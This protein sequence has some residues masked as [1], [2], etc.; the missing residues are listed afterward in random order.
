MKI[1]ILYERQKI[2]FRRPCVF[3]HLTYYNFTFIYG[4]RKK[5]VPNS[6]GTVVYTIDMLGKFYSARFSFQARRAADLII[7]HGT[8]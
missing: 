6:C 5:I 1:L 2:F 3:D 7:F 4:R 8:E